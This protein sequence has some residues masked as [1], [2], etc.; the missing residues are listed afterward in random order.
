MYAAVQLT[1]HTSEVRAACAVTWQ[2]YRLT[3]PCSDETTC[4]TRVCTCL[5][6]HV[7]KQRRHC[8]NYTLTTWLLARGWRECKLYRLVTSSSCT[9][10]DISPGIPT[11]YYSMS[12]CSVRVTGGWTAMQH[13]VDMISHCDVTE[14]N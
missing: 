2:K 14:S 13:S 7:R 5:H 10:T 12:E 3:P 1:Q 4:N 8:A 9:V 6:H 11:K